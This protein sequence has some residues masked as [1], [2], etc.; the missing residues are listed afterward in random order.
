MKILAKFIMIILGMLIVPCARV[1]SGMEPG[2]RFKTGACV[3]TPLF[4][5]VKFSENAKR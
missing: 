5:T 4:K 1:Q 2:V 3:I